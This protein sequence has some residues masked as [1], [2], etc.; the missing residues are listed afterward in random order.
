MG[1][2]VDLVNRVFSI[3]GIYDIFPPEWWLS[4]EFGKIC[5]ELP[6][7]CDLGDYL[8]AD[9]KPF[10]NN[11]ERMPVYFNHY[12]AGA[13]LRSAIHFGQML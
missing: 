1:E 13:S 11:Q 12:P 4:E 8:I 3:L 7:L 9:S 10:L 2:N 5:A 6:P